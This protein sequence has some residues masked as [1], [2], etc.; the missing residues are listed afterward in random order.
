MN[1]FFLRY[2]YMVP[3]TSYPVRDKFY[4]RTSITLFYFNLPAAVDQW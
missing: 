4:L 1:V 2:I 3:S